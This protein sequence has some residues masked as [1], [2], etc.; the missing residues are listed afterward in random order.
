[1]LKALRAKLRSS[2]PSG[3]PVPPEYQAVSVGDEVGPEPAPSEDPRRHGPRVYWC[4]WILGAAVLLGWNGESREDC[5][6]GSLS[7]PCSPD[8]QLAAVRVLLRGGPPISVITRELSLVHIL[9]RQ[10]A[11][12]RHRAARCRH[13]LSIPHLKAEGADGQVSP[14][15]RMRRALVLLN[16]TLA[17]TLFPVLPFLL[18]SLSE[19]PNLLLALLGGITLALGCSTAYLQS[20][21]FALAALWGS[22]EV[23]AV[24][25]GQ[26]GIGVLVAAAQFLLA[27]VAAFGPSAPVEG[28]PDPSGG[29]PDGSSGVLA[30]VGLWALA[31]AGT[32][33]C[34]YALRGLRGHTEFANVMMPHTNRVEDGT[35]GKG[36]G[37]TRSVFR[38]NRLVEL[39]AAWVFLVTLVGV[40]RT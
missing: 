14:A 13:C 30:G 34:F 5:I 1:M 20:S 3:R 35:A 39:S 18:P 28:L 33:G 17:V 10:L 6:N 37:L 2:D 38:K 12:P 23:L 15:A 4:F 29:D 9:F 25:S 16:V 32:S 27:Y 7:Y 21:T 40:P 19:S 22:P 8:L 11:I 31:A 26:G 24:M 36:K